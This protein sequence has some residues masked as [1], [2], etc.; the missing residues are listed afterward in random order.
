MVLVGLEVQ[1]E[2]ETS[3]GRIDLFVKTDRFYYKIELKQDESADKALAQIN[4]RNYALPFACGNHEVIKI[5]VDFST[6][7]RTITGWAVEKHH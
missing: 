6:K 2:M 3:E 5:G 4:N 7:T 1:T